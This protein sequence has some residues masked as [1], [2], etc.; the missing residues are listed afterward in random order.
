VNFDG[1][2]LSRITAPPTLGEHNDPIRKAAGQIWRRVRSDAA[3]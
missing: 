3:E 1:E 2:R